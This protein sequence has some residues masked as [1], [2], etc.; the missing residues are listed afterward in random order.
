M[1]SANPTLAIA[2]YVCERRYDDFPQQA[3]DNAKLAILDTIGVMFA[4]S[5]HKVGQIISDYAR[6]SGAVGPATVIGQGFQTAPELAALAN[7][8]M[9]HAHDYDDH[10]HAST[11]SLPVSLALG[12]AQGAS[13]KQLMLGYLVGRE[14]CLNLTKCFDAGGWE[15]SGP[16][17]RGWH[18]V[19]IAGAVGA[20]AAAAKMLELSPETTC[21]AFGITA[22]ISGGVFANRGTMTKPMHAGNAARDGVLAGTLASKGFTAD[23]TVFTAS[24]GFADVFGLP[25]GCIASA[26]ENLRAHIHIVEHGIGVKR[27]PACSPTHRYIEAMRLLKQ[28][29]QLSP[30]TVESIACTPNR[31]LRCLYPKT[32][33][34]CKF[35]AAFSLVATLIDGEVNLSNCTESFLRRDDVQALLARTT[36]LEKPPGGESFIR[37]KT[38]A[39]Q[40]LEQPLV[41]PR[42]LTDP[43]EIRRKFHACAA[44]VVG[45]DKAAQ[46]ESSVFGLE[47][48]SPV[49][50]LTRLL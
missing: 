44:P 23:Q 15:G 46:I 10:G 12:E 39:G 47:N 27:Y 35:S 49:T 21:T 18:A 30:G 31:S 45:A 4:G 26:A 38:V 5:R 2:N 17:G 50:T 24:G 22:S 8:I 3:I 48:L 29:Y 32:D 41:R 25:E 20:T 19:G 6:A 9:A 13:G 1:M 42:D 43:E 7:G 34:E 28:K 40:A 36:Y 14:V 37:V 11:Q 33:L 16:Q